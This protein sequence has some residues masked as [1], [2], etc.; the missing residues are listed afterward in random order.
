[1]AIVTPLDHIR[2]FSIIAHIDHGKSTL[3]DRILERT[4]TVAPRDMKEQ[5]LDKMDLERER[6][7]TIKSQ[8]V[9]I[10]YAARDGQTYQLNLI[11]TP[12]HV[13]FTY[14]VSRS[15]A[16]C[17]GA[18]LLVDATQG[19][20]AQTVANAYLAVDNDLEIIPVL[21][22]IDLPASDV[23]EAEMELHELT[24]ATHDE[25]LTISAKT[26]EGVD[27]VLEA[28]VQR[29]PPPEGDPAAPPRAL[30]F[31]SEYD[32]YRGVIAYVRVVDGHFDRRQ[33]VTLMSTGQGAEIEELGSFGPGMTPA[34]RLETGEVG[35]IITGV[36]DVAQVRVGDT[37]TDRRR[38]AGEALPGYKVVHP[39]VFTGLFPTE[40][41]KFEELR[42][43]LE[44]L[45][46]NDAALL[47]EPES[48]VALG[49]GFRCGFLGLLHMDIVRERLER[50]YGLEL[51]TTM[52]NVEYH[53]HLTGGGMAVVR[54]PAQMPEANS[55]ERVEEPY[56]TASILVPSQ[57]VGTIM[58]LCQGRRADFVDM[59]YLSPERVEM[60]YRLP[61][62]EIVLDFFDQLKTRTRGYASLDYD[63]SGYRASDL[64]K[65]DV[66]LAGEPVDALSLIIPRESAHQRGKALVTKL[67]QKI[68]RQLFEVPVQA[69][70]GNKVVA[71][72][73]VKAVRKDVTAKCYGGDISRKRKLLEKQK[74]GKKRMKQLGVV[75]VPQEA[76]LAVLELEPGAKDR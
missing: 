47:Y 17:E 36:K 26:G 19:V 4:G 54:N 5:L 21:N 30:I 41:D 18:V 32:Q 67:R 3:A 58:E 42:D 63:Y 8:A 65:L 50:E 62:A 59:K 37:I 46:L 24:G 74:E 16:A 60:H 56:V 53:A 48:S 6:G 64:V 11:D 25:I 71:R 69:A 61:L 45:K 13:D 34:E 35:Y 7:I 49:F 29:T 73:T 22:K 66:L 12:G 20:E 23:P 1:L 2:N 44:K 33:L 28:V 27:E 40:G 57:F 43:A 15:L 39:M 72:E 52:P 55:I 10:A 31:D 9:R 75:E 14:E 70:I 51:I 68:P 76:F 38:P